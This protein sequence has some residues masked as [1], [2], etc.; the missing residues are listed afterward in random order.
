M[1]STTTGSDVAGAIWFGELAAMLRGKKR[2]AMAPTVSHS[3]HEKERLG[4]AV[5]GKP[6]TEAAAKPG[7]AERKE[8]GA[9]GGGVS[10]A[11]VYMLFDRFAP[12]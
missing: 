2:Q 3:E 8:T 7:V 10:D 5:H 4:G 1:S 12:S 6:K 9:G 11:T